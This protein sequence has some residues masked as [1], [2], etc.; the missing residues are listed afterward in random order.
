METLDRRAYSPV[1]EPNTTTVLPSPEAGAVPVPVPVP[2]YTE[3]S[4]HVT[5]GIVGQPAGTPMHHHPDPVINMQLHAGTLAVNPIQYVRNTWRL[6]IFEFGNLGNCLLAF[7]CPCFRFALTTARAAVSSFVLLSMI[8]AFCQVAWTV[9]NVI[10]T[11]ETIVKIHDLR[12]HHRHESWEQVEEEDGDVGFN[13]FATINWLCVISL[14]TIGTMV[15]QQIRAKY[16]IP[17]T[18]CEDWL[19]HCFC[20]CCALAQEGGHVDLAELG[21]VQPWLPLTRVGVTTP[22]QQIEQVPIAHSYPQMAMMAT[23]SHLSQVQYVIP[24]QPAPGG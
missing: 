22:T 9:V 24:A 21:S 17:G 20:T 10:S 8:Y 4:S 1:P 14:V 5:V 11:I 6:Q 12:L 19:L 3:P 23:A 16:N 13:P 7:F 15:R 2:V 18:C